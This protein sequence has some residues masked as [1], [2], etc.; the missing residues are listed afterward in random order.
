MFWTTY[1]VHKK[2]EMHFIEMFD[3]LTCALN[4]RKYYD[5]YVTTIAEKFKL[6][7]NPH[8]ER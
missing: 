3:M 6:E 4:K 7:H 8:K 5:V 2:T 1:K